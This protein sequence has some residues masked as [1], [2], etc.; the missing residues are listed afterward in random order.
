MASFMAGANTTGLRAARSVAVTMSSDRPPAARPIRLAV[1]GATRISCAQS[2]RWTCGSGLPTGAH[3][4]VST[5]L[6]VTPWKVGGPTK[7]VAEGVI[8]TRT[9]LPAC[10]SAEARST[11]LYAAIPPETSTAIRRPRSSSGMGVWSRGILGGLSYAP[12]RGVD[13]PADLRHGLL[14]VVVGHDMVVAR[15]VGQLPLGDATPGDHVLCR[16]AAALHLAPLK[17]LLGRRHD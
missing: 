17:L 10:V 2:P 11:I 7:R 5:G 8:A 3:M 6:P 13:D 15:R 12:A 14:D 16:L 9:S 4:P 1:A